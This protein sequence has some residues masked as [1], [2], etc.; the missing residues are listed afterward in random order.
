VSSVTCV[1]VGN[2]CLGANWLFIAYRIAAVN[3]IVCQHKCQ[4]LFSFN[5]YTR[6]LTMTD[7]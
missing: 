4:L 6:Y 3:G 5:A 2:Y 7:M 1:L